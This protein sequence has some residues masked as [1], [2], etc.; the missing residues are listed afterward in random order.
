MGQGPFFGMRGFVKLFWVEKSCC[1]GGF[2]KAQRSTAK[3]TWWSF[4]CWLC[5]CAPLGQP[6]PSHI[7]DYQF[8][9]WS[10][11][12][13]PI[14]PDRCQRCPYSEQRTGTRGEGRVR[15]L[16]IKVRSLLAF[17][18]PQLWLP[19]FSDSPTSSQPLYPWLILPKTLHPDVSLPLL[20][21]GFIWTIG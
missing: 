17:S 11:V 19:F 7:L 12:S 4:L 13:I 6:P 18:V 8:S 20:I 2:I 15:R 3:K 10:L 14:K 16:R 1:C 5:I 21:L 9:I